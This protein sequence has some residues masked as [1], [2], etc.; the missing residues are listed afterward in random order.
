MNVDALNRRLAALESVTTP[1]GRPPA[2]IVENGLFGV[3][4]DG[5][6][7][8]FPTVEAALNWLIENHGEPVAPDL[9][10]KIVDPPERPESAEFAPVSSTQPKPLPT[11]ENAENDRFDAQESGTKPKPDHPDLRP[12]IYF[13][14]IT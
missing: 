4:I 6:A 1:L 14:E 3:S 12:G 5:F 9:V 7:S 13:Y 8:D 10:L 2:L 11:A